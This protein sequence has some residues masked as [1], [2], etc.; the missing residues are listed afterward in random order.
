MGGRGGFSCF[1]LDSPSLIINHFLDE[2]GS[3]VLCIL[4]YIMLYH[5]KTKYGK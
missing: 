4:Y 1:C 5:T 2:V 3:F